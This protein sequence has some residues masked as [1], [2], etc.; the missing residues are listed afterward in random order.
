THCPSQT[1][2]ARHLRGPW[3]NFA[4]QRLPT[5]TLPPALADPMPFTPRSL[6]KTLLPIP[7]LLALPATSVAAPGETVEV[8][9]DK[10]SSARPSKPSLAL[11]VPDLSLTSR[12]FD[13]PTGL[14]IIMQSE[15]SHPVVSVLMVVDH[16]AAD[17]PDQAMGTAHFVEHTWF[18]SKHQDRPPIMT[19]IQDLGTQFNATTRHDTTDFRTVA[20]SEFINELMKL[21]SL[22]LTEP[23]IGVTDEEIETER[24]VV[25]NEWR[26]RNEQSSSL[27]FDYLLKSVFPDDHP[28]H[29]RETND[30]LDNIKLPVL[31]KYFDDYYTPDKTT[32][33]V[34]GDFDQ[35]Q[36]RSLVFSNFDLA[37]LDPALK[38]EHLVTYPKPGIE[39][40]NPDMPEHWLTDAV[41]PANPEQPYPELDPRKKQARV[42][43]SDP[44]PLPPPPDQ[45]E[46]P[47]YK[48]AIDNQTVMVGWALPGGFRGDDTNMV[49][50]ANTASGTIASTLRQKGYLDSDDRKRGLKDPG[51]FA[52]PL[53]VNSVIACS[54]EVTD[55]KRWDDPKRVADLMIDQLA[56]VWNPE[57]VTLRQQFVSQ[58]KNSEIARILRSVDD[59]AQHFGG[60]AED[61]G[62]HA[63]QTASVTFHSDRIREIAALDN[64]RVAQLGY[65][66][67]KRD[68]AAVAVVN[69]IPQADIDTTAESS[70]YHGASESDAVADAAIA[71]T[72]TDEDIANEYLPPNL[73]RLVDKRMPNGLRVVIVPHGESP[74]VEATLV[75]GG[76]S[77]DEPDGIRLLTRIFQ[78]DDWSSFGGGGNNALQIA[79]TRT[80]YQDYGTQWMTG[81]RGPAGN[82]DGALWMLREEMES[83][84]PD[85]DGKVTYTNRERDKFYSGIH[86]RG[87]HLSEMSQ[88][89]LYPETPHQ[90]PRTKGYVDQMASFTPADARTYM[91][92]QLQP[93]NATLVVVGNIDA[94]E[95]LRQSVEYFAGWEPRSGVEVGPVAKPAVPPMGT[96]SKI[97]VFDNQ[98]RTQTQ[99][100]RECRLNYEGVQDVQATAVLSNLIFDRTFSTLRVKEALAYSPGGN[101]SARPDGSADLTFRSLAVNIGV[102]RTLEFFRDLTQEIEDGKV[103]DAQLT[104]YKLRRSRSTGVQAQ[105]T[106]QMTRKLLSVLYWDQPWSMLTDAGQ[107]VADVDAAQLQRMVKGC[108]GRSITT[109]EGPA[110]VITPQLDAK[111][112]KYEIVDYKERGNKMHESLDPKGYK[113]HLK[114]KAKADKKREKDKAKEVADGSADSESAE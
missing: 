2:S 49:V 99:V 32:I 105:S 24:E 58:G 16:G 22:R 107:H 60:R 80:F 11:R 94:D 31:Q 83:K 53:K 92:R 10:P 35:A 42:K 23:Y 75:I 17:D 109:L 3:N 30:S 8:I 88:R 114:A 37:L 82:L 34:V 54:I 111:G 77:W 98:K 84:R 100:T 52:L 66:F 43:A 46:I 95:A 68:R 51:C 39:N 91:D 70:S 44:M 14:R 64:A 106:S 45:Q 61:I 28:Y 5:A 74:L 13:F 40:P 18:R 65:E 20:S 69:P 19:H 97:L 27:V 21:E 67:L 7:L 93:A 6:F 79:A 102:G 38:P 55:T 1:L 12:V 90:W 33:I 26:R 73:G 4:A 96:G 9:D 72:Y 104:K 15:K 81:I 63:H 113:K 101:A 41:N 36:A 103:D 87:W 56:P 112:F 76:G 25:R 50:L 47:V 78:D 59:V 85:F 86:T 71:A 108:N 29:E 110:D 62:F 89:H 57:L 48:A